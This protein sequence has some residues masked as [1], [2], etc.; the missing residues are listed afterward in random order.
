M[1]SLLRN[2]DDSGRSMNAPVMQFTAITKATPADKGCWVDGH[3]GQYG[4][5]RVI[6]LAAD[7]GYGGRNGDIEIAARMLSTHPFLEVTPS[8]YEVLQDNA[9]HVEEWLNNYVAPTGYSFGWEDGEFFLWPNS[10][11]EMID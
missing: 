2:L 9:D 5:A 1:R 10:L 8:E 11:W 4:I 6:T 7:H 3:W